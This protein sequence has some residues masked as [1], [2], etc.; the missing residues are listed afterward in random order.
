MSINRGL[1]GHWTLDGTDTSNGVVYDRSS[2][3]RHG[4][5]RNGVSV[6]VDSVIGEAFSFDGNDDFIRMP[7]DPYTGALDDNTARMSLSCWLYPTDLKS[8][9]TNHAIQ[10]CWMAHSS[11]NDN[12]N[13]EMGIDSST[14][15]IQV[16]FDTNGFDNQNTNTGVTSPLNTWTHV[17]VTLDLT[18]TPTMKLYKNGGLELTDTNTWSGTDGTL[19]DAG[20]AE[21][22][23]AASRS[24]REPY[25]GRLS[26]A[27]LYSRVLS[28]S[29]VRRLYNIRSTSG[30]GVRRFH[31]YFKSS[32]F[33]NVDNER[34]NIVSDRV[35]RGA[36]SA[37]CNNSGGEQFSITPYDSPT[38]P[39]Y[40][41]YR[42]NEV[43][44]STGSG[45]R[46][47]NSNGNYEM[48]C[49]LDNPEWDIED[50][51]GFSETVDQGNYDEWTKFIVFFDWD[52]GTFNI[53]IVGPNSGVEYI[54]KDRPLINGQDF[55]TVEFWNYN[56]TSWGGNSIEAW[57]DDILIV[58]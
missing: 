20:G 17:V 48:G 13:M 49:A 43:S 33:S 16:Y 9:S 10:N 56:S 34:A 21:F 12:D 46:V 44:N 45:M 22:T 38:K 4:N 47:K 18:G 58:Y 5:L 31:E 51:N 3:D 14:N 50:G 24:F 23:L 25:T 57:F 42:N 54:D 7:Q 11:T 55:K 28:E 40:I 37:F 19:D 26:D 41:Q 1:V 29:D 2:F 15:D 32:D 39:S 36:N 35:Y 52:S 53:Q 8:A 6:S 27:R 30:L